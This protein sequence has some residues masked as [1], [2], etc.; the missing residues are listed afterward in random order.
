[1]DVGPE[2]GADYINANYINGEADGSE[3]AYIA[4]Q[5]TMPDTLAAFWQMTFEN[6]CECVCVYAASVPVST[7]TSAC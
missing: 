7:P 2:V 3:K 6:N 1:V 4:S 5:G